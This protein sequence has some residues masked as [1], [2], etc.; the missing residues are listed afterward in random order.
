MGSD[1]VATNVLSLVEPFKVEEDKKEIAYKDDWVEVRPIMAS[2]C[3]A[4]LRYFNGSRGAEVLK[5]KLPMALIH[6]GIGIVESSKSEEFSAGDRVAI[7][8]NIPNRVLQ[9]SV[10]SE[11][12]KIPANY[13]SGAEFLGSNRDGI[14]QTRLVHPADCLVKIPDNISDELAVLSE[15]SSVSNHAI[16]HIESDLK[17]TSKNIA[18][19]G[20]GPVGYL[21][22]CMISF[23]FHVEKERFTVF[24]ADAERLA[25]FDFA[26][27]KMSPEYNFKEPEKKYDVIIECTGGNFSAVAINEAIDLFNPIGKLVLM[28]VS[29]EKAPINTRDVLEKGLTLYGSSRSTTYNFE[30]VIEGM[31]TI[32]EYRE[33]L[34]RILPKGMNK[35]FTVSSG[36]DFQ[37][38]MN[39]ISNDKTWEK[40]IL[41][42]NY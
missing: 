40:A 20:D 27:T 21:T 35:H 19:F 42:F 2:V 36:L 37:N 31:T 28:G 17:D 34:S 3:H 10:A 32:P 14:A 1:T 9:P 5:K 41:N 30:K 4:D 38:A 23:M 26:E 12:Q 7:V 13:A 6:E 39:S 18:L 33:A 25:H 24:G 29:E 15:V 22:A 11:G 8:P 16:S